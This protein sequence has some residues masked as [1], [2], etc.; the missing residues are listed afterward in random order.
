MSVFLEPAAPAI[1]PILAMNGFTAYVDA[2][3]WEQDTTARYST[4][5]N[6]WF[7]SV[8][9]TSAGVKAIWARLLKGEL[10]TMRQGIPHRADPFCTLAPEGP[11]QW[12][13]TPRHLPLAA[14]HQMVLLPECARFNTTGRT[15]FLLMPQTEDDA[16]GLHYRFLDKRVPLPL[17]PQ[18]TAW[19]WDRAVRQGE[20]VRLESH[21][22]IAYRCRPNVE[23][24]T[25]DVAAAVRNRVLT[26][27]E[28]A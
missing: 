24:L 22:C 18:W 10:G 14:A 16:A 13:M 11:K 17:H 12:K 21:G 2:Y 26:I 19:L 20:A 8:V 25:A 9:G 3:A 15:D 6:L 7:I 28:G 4:K 27:T 23:A 1:S 5:M